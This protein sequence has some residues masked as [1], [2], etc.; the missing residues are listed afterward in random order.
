MS[1][2]KS[3]VREAFRDAVFARDAYRCRIC[4]FEPARDQVIELLDAHHITDRANMPGGGYVKENGISLCAECHLRAE[5][6]HQTGA[7]TEGWHPDDLYRK[8]GSS[9]EKAVRASARL[10]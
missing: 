10:T 2:Q 8:I 6:Y 7:A 5:E 4:G 9:H 3:L 1:R